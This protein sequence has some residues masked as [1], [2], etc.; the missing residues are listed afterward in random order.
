MDTVRMNP[1]ASRVVIVEDNPVTRKLLRVTLETA[2]YQVAEAEDARTGFELVESTRPDFVI[3]DYVLPDTTGD[4]LCRRIRRTPHG[5]HVPIVLLSGTASQIDPRDGGFNA[6]LMKPFEPSRLLEQIKAIRNETA[7]PSS[8]PARTNFQGAALSLMSAISEVL[9]RP[10]EGAAALG[11][12]MLHCLDAFGIASGVLYVR[13]AGGELQ[14]HSHAGLPS[15]ALKA[16]AHA[17]DVPEVIERVRDEPR[18]LQAGLGDASEQRFLQ[19]FGHQAALLIPF[20]ILGQSRGVFV[21]GA[22]PETLSAPEWPMFARALGAQLGQIAALGQAS[23]DAH[24]AERLI[25]Q[26]VDASPGGLLMVDESGAI[27]LANP[28]IE[29]IFGYQEAELKGKSVEL[30]LPQSL[31]DQHAGDRKAFLANPVKRQMGVGRDLFGRHKSGRQVP[32]EIG[33]APVLRG[34]RRYIIATVIDISE[35]LRTHEAE[36]RSAATLAAAQQLAH[37]GSYEFD[38]ATGEG[39]I[40]RELARIY[41]RDEREPPPRFPAVLLKLVH[42]EDLPRVR[43]AIL[44]M[45]AGAEV[46]SRDSY[47][48]VRPDGE[49][50][51]LD[52]Y[53]AIERDSSGTLARISGALLDVTDHHNIESELTNA[54]LRL[55]ALSQRL[56]HIQESERRELARELHDEIG[57]ALTASQMNLQSI[58]RYPDEPRLPERLEEASASIARALNQ[59]RSL[60]LQLRPPLIDELGLVPALRW[61]VERYASSTDV[62][63]EFVAEPSS[64]RPSMEIEIASFR[65]A[66]EALNNVMRHAHARKVRVALTSDESSLVLRVT[67]DGHGFSVDESI[68]RATHGSSLGLVGM[69]ERARLAGGAV[70]WTSETGRGTEVR[71]VFPLAAA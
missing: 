66:Q 60:T 29:Q 36:R 30:L 3:L 28:M 2:G 31:R 26:A 65:I 6:C 70:T 38:P 25:R 27:V 43:K 11:D 44:D 58:A 68:A 13:G 55:E 45:F 67:D 15:Q 7:M 1:S 12:I 41:G 23:A 8:H 10:V 71:A 22:D 14:F 53:R 52:A 16:A 54:R 48:I 24:E 51:W 18:T 17:F 4:E 62:A 20:V 64:R 33:L 34:H 42:P 39:A 19:N 61:L 59:V 69:A 49:I 21:L 32:V 46:E 35:R 47:R 57:Q 40:S 56:L 37:L 9:S 5:R 50:R 63:F